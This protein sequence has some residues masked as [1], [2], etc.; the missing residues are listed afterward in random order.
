MQPENMI[1]DFI[2]LRVLNPKYSGALTIVENVTTT[3]EQEDNKPARSRDFF[4]FGIKR[5]IYPKEEI[6][7]VYDISGYFHKDN[8]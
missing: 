3:A 8:H 2:Y 5:V 4:S 6:E 7:K 1:A